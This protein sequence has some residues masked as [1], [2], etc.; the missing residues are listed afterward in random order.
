[1]DLNVLFDRLIPEDAGEEAKKIVDRLKSKM[2]ENISD[3]GSYSVELSPDEED[4][5]DTNPPLFMRQQEWIKRRDRK[6]FE[7]KM[8]LEADTMRDITGKP[9]LGDAKR[10]W[11][12]AKEAHEEALERAQ[13]N[14]TPNKGLSKDNDKD[15]GRELKMIDWQKAKE[16]HDQALKR[17]IQQEDIKRQAR[18]EKEKA[19]AMEEIQNIEIVG[20]KERPQQSSFQSREALRKSSVQLIEHTRR[21]SKLKQQEEIFLRS[22]SN[23]NSDV[24]GESVRKMES[25]INAFLGKSY[26]E[27]SEKEFKKLVKRLLISDKTV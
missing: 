11:I 22:K 4:F 5:A 13:Q 7:A 16:S 26:S 21:Q 10:S 20:A 3:F 27:M 17:A 1:M 9:A 15:K 18:E 8:Q 25:N 6:R 2:Y 19:A 12:M 14:A 24:S 23:V